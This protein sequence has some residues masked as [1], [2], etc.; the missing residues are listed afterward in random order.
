MAATIGLNTQEQ[1]PPAAR[2]SAHLS[3]TTQY[4]AM[5]THAPIP[6]VMTEGPQHTRRAVSRS[7]ARLVEL[8][9][10]L[11]VGRTLAESLRLVAGDTLLQHFDAVYTSGQ[12]LLLGDQ[13]HSHTVHGTVVWSY[14]IL[15]I[16]RTST[17]VGACWSKSII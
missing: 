6:L 8:E 16:L 3:L 10:S 13:T 1:D 15:P 17:S 14:T 2:T 11:L 4:A 12:S 9:A 5:T 7:F